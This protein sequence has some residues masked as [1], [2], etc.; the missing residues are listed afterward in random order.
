MDVD[1][2][3]SQRTEKNK[4]KEKFDLEEFL[5]KNKLSLGIGLLGIFLLGIGILS[6]VVLSSRQE[7][8]SIEILPAGETEESSEIFVHVAGA[9]QRP[10]LYKLPSSARVN[11]ALIAAG[12]LSAKADRQWFSKSVNLAQKLSDGVRLYIPYKGE[13][14]IPIPESNLFSDP[15]ASESQGKIN[16]NTASISELDSLPGIGPAYAKRIIDSRPFAKIEDI[17]E[18]EGIGQKTFEKI[19]D[20]ITVF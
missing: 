6:A 5:A 17:M 7:S 15:G 19:K 20:K 13:S 18:V 11:D 14:A 9:V 3:L 8:A 1:L 2:P 10:G 12:G 16:I 4:V